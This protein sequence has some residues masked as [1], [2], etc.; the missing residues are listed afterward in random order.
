[1]PRQCRCRGR[2]YWWWWWLLRYVHSLFWFLFLVG[3]PLSWLFTSLVGKGR[4]CS[5]VGGRSSRIGR[6]VPNYLGYHTQPVQCP[7]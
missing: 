6:Y 7:I 3:Q 5:G 1:M 2:A 4:D